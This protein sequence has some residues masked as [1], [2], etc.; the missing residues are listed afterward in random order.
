MLDPRVLSD[1]LANIKLF[2]TDFDGIHT[3]G[4]LS[5]NEQGIESVQCSRKDG[6]AFEMLRKAE[7]HACIISKETNLVVTMRAR[8]LNIPVCQGVESGEGKLTIL[9]RFADKLE[10]SRENV[11][12][13]GDD[14]NDLE[15]LSWAGVS[16]TV[17]DAHP[18]VVKC[19]HFVTLAPGGQHAIREVVEML[20][21]AKGLFQTAEPV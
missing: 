7:I 21:T 18:L 10:L 19:A 5:V 3:N 15:P 16:I 2:A 17:S 13:M 6:L 12:Y 14:I 20:L 9:R 8:K 1:Y 4:F 11:L